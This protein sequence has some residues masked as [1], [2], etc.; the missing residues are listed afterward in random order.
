MY[1]VIRHLFIP[2]YD[3]T[4]PNLLFA[5]NPNLSNFTGK[6]NIFFYII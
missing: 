5:T 3:V 2:K 1:S 4:G 6:L